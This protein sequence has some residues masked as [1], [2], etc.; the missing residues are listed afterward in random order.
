M[1]QEDDNN[2]FYIDN[3]VYANEEKELSLHAY[4]AKA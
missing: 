4:S 3:I 1:S 2:T